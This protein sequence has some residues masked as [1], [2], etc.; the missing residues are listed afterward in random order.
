MQRLLIL[1]S[2][3]LGKMGSRSGRNQETGHSCLPV[4]RHPVN[5]NTRSLEI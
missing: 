4:G 3:T 1:C 5:Y 2:G